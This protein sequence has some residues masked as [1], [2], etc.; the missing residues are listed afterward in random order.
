MPEWWPAFNPSNENVFYLINPQ[1]L[2]QRHRQTNV[3]SG[4]AREY[5]ENK[6]LQITPVLKILPTNCS[7]IYIYIY[8][9]IYIYIFVTYMA[10]NVAY[11]VIVRKRYTN[12]LFLG[13]K[14]ICWTS[15]STWKQVYQFD[16]LRCFTWVIRE[17][18][19]CY[20]VVGAS[21]WI[22]MRETRHCRVI[23]RLTELFF[24]IS[25]LKFII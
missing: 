2:Q 8:M 1:V 5:R 25:N 20:T 3:R 4:T 15:L 22:M 11:F 17:F 18:L 24:L 10:I 6:L 9:Y 21:S 19:G 14:A 23:V 13:A 7:I 16:I 12:R